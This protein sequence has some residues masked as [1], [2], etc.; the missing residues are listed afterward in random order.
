MECLAT[1]NTYVKERMCEGGTCVS[2]ENVQMV[3]VKLR[4]VGGAFSA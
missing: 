2:D 1:V 3:V 4:F